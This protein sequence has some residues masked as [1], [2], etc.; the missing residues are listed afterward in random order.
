MI[1]LNESLSK[2]FQANMAD[3]FYSIIFL[4]RLKDETNIRINYNKL[5]S[6]STSYG[7]VISNDLNQN[8]LSNIDTIT[9][10]VKQKL[11]ADQQG[12]TQ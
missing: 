5:N 6:G 11:L 12:L 8:F 4:K 2:Y 7:I 3:E 10:E 9:K 1:N